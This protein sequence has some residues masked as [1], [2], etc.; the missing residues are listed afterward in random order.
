MASHLNNQSEN[1]IPFEMPR[2]NWG[3]QAR[4]MVWI[5]GA[6]FLMWLGNKIGDNPRGI[7]QATINGLLLGGIYSLVAVGVVIINKATGIFNFAHGAMMLFTALVFYS[8]YTTPKDS[9]SL[10]AVGALAVITVL[11]FIGMNRLRDILNPAKLGV[12]AVVAV[13]LVAVMTQIELPLIRAFVGGITFAVLMGLLIERLAI[14]PLVGQP[15]FTMILMT[16]ALDALFRGISLMMW[17]SIDKTLGLYNGVFQQAGVENPSWKIP[18]TIRIDAS[19][20]IDGRITTVNMASGSLI[21][22]VIALILFVLF[23]L[24]FQYTNV[25]LAMRATSENQVLA[26]SIGM[27]VRAILATAWAIA[28]L[29]ALSAGVLYGSATNIGTGMVQLVFLAFPAV[30]LGGLESIGGALIGGLIIGLAQNY[31]DFLF[32]QDAG[33]QLVPYIIL[34][35]VLIIKPDGLFGQRRIER[36]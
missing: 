31:G 3:K 24:F 10:I 16:L 34:M 23:I 7:I 6:I 19:A 21:A 17:G 15:V 5:I 36:I 1:Y 2:I 20:F 14:R 29:L 4:G 26:Q 13:V 35:V 28:A 30:L 33:T 27:R 18:A 9:I 32:A 11:A 8:F 22:F 12:G 25:G